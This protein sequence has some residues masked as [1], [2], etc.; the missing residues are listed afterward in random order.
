MAFVVVTSLLDMVEQHLLQLN[1]SLI[2][3]VKE[4]IVSLSHKLCTLQA[5]LEESR[6]KINRP[7][8]MEADIRGVAAQIEGE[9]KSVM[10]KVYQAANRRGM[11]VFW[12]YYDLSMALEQAVTNIE[13]IES[14]ILVQNANDFS[15]VGSSTNDFKE[16]NVMVGGSLQYASDIENEIIVG[17]DEDIEEIV[18]MAVHPRSIERDIISIVGE[19]G[20]G[21]TTLAKVVF[22]DQRITACFEIRAWVLVSKEYNL[23][24][25][26][27]GLLRC[28]MPITR[29]I[30]N[31]DEAQLEEKLCRSLMGKRYLIFL[32]DVWTMEVWDAI[33]RC[34]PHNS[35]E[36]NPIMLTTRVV[37]V[38]E[39]LSYFCD[40][41]RMKFQNLENSWKLF[42]MKVFCPPALEKLGRQIS[43]QCQGLPLAIIVI[44]RFLAATKGSLEVWRKVAETL[45]EMDWADDKTSKILLLS[46]DYLPSQLKACFLYFGVFPRNCC[47]PIKKLINLWVAEGFL[48]LE[49]NKSLEEVAENCLLDLTNRSLVQV[50]KVSID[51]KMKECRIHDRLHEICVKEAEKENI[52]RIVDETHA[53]QVYRWISCQSSHWPI[54]QASCGENMSSEIHSILFFGKDFYFSK[55]RL[56]YSCLK[57]LTVLDLSLVKYLHGMPSGITDLI[58]LR[59][60]ALSTIGSLYKFRLLKLQNLQTLIVCSW[61]EEYPLQLACDILD[62][63]QLR[64]LR[65]EKRCSQYL[66]SVVRENLQ[67]L[68]WLKVTSLERKPNFRMV[69]NLKELGIYIEGGL[70]PGC[71]DSL[72]HLHLLEK[73]KFEIGRVERFCLPTAFPS[74][75]KKL[76]FRRSYLPWEKMG[77]IGKLQQLEVL[78]LKDFAFRGPKWEPIDGEFR[79]LKVLLI[80]YSDLKQWN[81][82]VC[83]F[84]VLERLIL[85]NCW[86]LEKVPDSFANMRTM[87]LI[88]L[89]NC[90]SPLVASTNQFSSTNML[91]FKKMP[92]EA[93]RVR[94]VGT[95]VELPNNEIS[96]E[97]NVE[98]SEEEIVEISEEESA[99]SSN[100]EKGL[101][102]Q[103]KALKALKRNALRL[104]KLKRKVW[105][106]LRRK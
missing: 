101:K 44:A 46:Y 78:K 57:V 54:T 88:E 87:K 71:V 86:D 93:L 50:D 39:H 100:N 61:M 67:T 30:S 20:I 3:N 34:F 49:K 38:A 7:H 62:L 73:L 76:T 11:Y 58:H 18:H 55:C 32:D 9:I 6:E 45:K 77:V 68:Y 89:G 17:F 47:I 28:I 80:A 83:H 90:T 69:P 64:H 79:V 2:R 19:G 21:K 105:R 10:R 63:P 97:E 65:L 52:V 16:D 94:H 35:N 95:K 48:K 14:R 24:E 12:E 85:R 33:K 8:A 36:R 92:D 1:P 41:K 82:N 23:K 81:V 103:K 91:L 22:Q 98:S 29:D 43:S 42:S 60:L 104:S 31:M 26:L 75:L 84:P 99:E 51:G 66:P 13:K 37:D 56:V 59:Y 40:I 53:L 74:N 5:F 102:A 70:L 25:M 27:I 96:E 4:I 106:A 15:Y 72:V